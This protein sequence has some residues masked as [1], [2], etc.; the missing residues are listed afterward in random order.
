MD[1]FPTGGKHLD[2]L[3][4]TISLSGASPRTSFLELFP[5]WGQAPGPP[6]QGYFL[7]TFLGVFCHTDEAYL[8]NLLP[9][10]SP[11]VPFPGGISLLG[12]STWTPIPQGFFL[13]GQAPRPPIVK[14]FA[15]FSES[16]QYFETVRDN[17]VCGILERKPLN[18]N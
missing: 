13:L 9:G 18:F 15:Y 17:E 8:S 1:Y 14:V 16:S 3:P 11:W 2:P 4:W 5:Y 6:S 10:A 12:A 7:T